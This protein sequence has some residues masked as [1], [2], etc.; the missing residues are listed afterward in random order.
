MNRTFVETTLS[1]AHEQELEQPDPGEIRLLALRANTDD[2]TQMR[3]LVFT[4]AFLGEPF[5]VTCPC[6]RWFGDVVLTPEIRYQPAHIHVAVHQPSGRLV[7][8]ST[9]ATGGQQF[10]TLQYN[11]VRKQVMSLAISLF[12]PRNFFAQFS[13]Q[14][15]THMIFKGERERPRHPQTGVH[16]HYQVA[17]E[18]R[19]K[20]VGTALLRRFTQAAIRDGSALIWAEVMA[21]PEKPPAYFETRGWSIFGDHVDFPVQVLSITRALDSF[22]PLTQTG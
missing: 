6:K 11:W 9:G 19:G 3:E 13:R 4:N 7:G 14:F 18:F 21:Y 22:E 12:L 10:E 8:Y 2:E 16:W 5:D 20:G 15:T 1:V 17:K